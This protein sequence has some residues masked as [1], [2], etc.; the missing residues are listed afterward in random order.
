MRRR[1]L[2]A[3]FFFYLQRDDKFLVAVISTDSEGSRKAGD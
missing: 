1:S 3:P 2:P